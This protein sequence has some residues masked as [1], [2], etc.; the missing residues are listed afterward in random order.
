LCAYLFFSGFYKYRKNTGLSRLKTGSRKYGR[1]TPAPA[2]CDISVFF[3]NTKINRINIEIRTGRDGIFSV[4][5]HASSSDSD[6]LPWQQPLTSGH[7]SAHMGCGCLGWLPLQQ[8][9]RRAWPHGGM[10]L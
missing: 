3:V 10:G 9:E 1:D 4:H 5:F 8:Q 7:P 2:S 6:A